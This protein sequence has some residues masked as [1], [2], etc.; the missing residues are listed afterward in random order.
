[1][2]GFGNRR[3][4]YNPANEHDACGIGMICS[5]RNEASRKIV[6]DGLKIL[7]NLEHRGAVGAD[8]KAGDGAG[9][10]IQLPHEFFAAETKTLGFELPAPNYYGVAHLFMPQDDGQRTAIEAA[11]EM[12]ADMEG[13]SIIGWRDVPVDSSIL[14]ESVKPTEPV[15]R[16]VFIA[17][18]DGI[19]DDDTFERACA[20]YLHGG[21]GG[22]FICHSKSP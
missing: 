11:Y 22:I 19:A 21:G 14:G 15:Q 2:T 5:I 18:G 4:L 6:E 10:L 7:C 8:S 1:M 13:L 9:I 12:A 3:G 17:R 16:Q 20:P